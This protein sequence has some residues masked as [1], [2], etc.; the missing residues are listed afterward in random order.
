MAVRAIPYVTPHVYLEWERKADTKSEYH[1]G[2]IVAMAG[3]SKEHN[4]ITFDISVSLGEQLRETRCQGFSNYMRVRVPE[5]DKYYYPDVVVVCGEPQF[6]DAELDTLLNPTL[7]IEVLSD[8]TEAKDRGEKL[9]CYQTLKSMT[10][11]VLVSQNSPR[12]ETYQRQGDGSWRYEV[13]QGIEAVL[14]LDTIGCSLRLADIFARVT[15]PE[16]ENNTQTQDRET[17]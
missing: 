3:S 2:V 10:T 13:T 11:Y 1:H 6:E 8:T 7:L 5:C 9:L 12:A 4:A 14:T 16:A 15:F 17:I